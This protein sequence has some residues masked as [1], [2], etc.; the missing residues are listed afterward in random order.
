MLVGWYLR[1]A[2]PWMA[3]LGCCAAALLLAVALDRWPTTALVLLPALVA[4]CAASAAFTFDEASLPVVEVTP[5]G[6]TWRRAAR[7]AVALVPLGV[8]AL[9]V[10]VRP[11]DLP[12][13]R[14]SWL[15]VG[16]ATIGLTVGLAALAS[17]HAMASPGGSLAAAVVL[18]VI[19]PVVVCAFLGWDSLY[20]IGDFSAGVLA[21]WLALTGVAALACVAAIRTGVGH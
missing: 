3:L 6:A 14:P 4:S 9:F 1:R 16:L 2:I 7:L 5:R 8:W 17:R 21:F 20:P 15:L 13:H 18:A 19:S 12:L 10:V 11:G